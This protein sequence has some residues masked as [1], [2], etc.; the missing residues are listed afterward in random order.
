M[1]SDG[2]DEPAG[3]GERLRAGDMLKGTC[4]LSPSPSWPEAVK[5][6]GVDV[7]FLDTEHVAL[8]RHQLSWM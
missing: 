1:A 4:I 7:V 2:K 8:D 3:L 6:T 5:A